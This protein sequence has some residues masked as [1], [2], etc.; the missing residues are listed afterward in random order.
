MSAPELPQVEH[1]VLTKHRDPGAA[2]LDLI[3][4]LSD[5]GVRADD[6]VPARI[7]VVGRTCDQ[8]FVLTREEFNDD[9]EVIAYHYE[10]ADPAIAA[11]CRLIVYND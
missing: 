4:E 2:R 11:K 6:P 9:N 10:A 3:G 5:L 7:V 1:A 8:V